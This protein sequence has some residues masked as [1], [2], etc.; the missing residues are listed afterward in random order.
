[1]HVLVGVT[2]F[3]FLCIL[4]CINSSN[5]GRNNPNNEKGIV[6]CSGESGDIF[7]ELLAMIIQIR[8]KLQSH[9]PISVAHC[10]ELTEISKLRLLNISHVNVVNLCD[11]SVRDNN[12]LK[13][14][15]CKPM[16][17]IRSPFKHTILA[18]TDVIWFAKP[19]R[20]FDAPAFISTGALYF[21]DRLT[22]TKNKLTL[23]KGL[24][25]AEFLYSY[26]NSMY[27]KLKKS[28]ELYP[29]RKLQESPIHN[30]KNNS[31]NEIKVHKKGHVAVDWDKDHIIFNKSLLA[32]SNAYWRH[33][34]HG[35]GATL[36]HMQDSSVVVFDSSRHPR[37][38]RAIRIMLKDF[39]IGYGDKEMYWISSLV[40]NEAFTFEPYFAG[41]LGNCGALIHF[42]PTNTSAQAQP[43]YVNAEYLIDLRKMTK[44]GDFLDL[45]DGKAKVTFPNLV[46]EQSS[47]I[48][49]L[50]QWKKMP[51][52][53]YP[54]GS[55]E[56]SPSS[57]VLAS[58]ALIEEI[59]DRQKILL[60]L[61][62]LQ[63]NKNSNSEFDHF[64]Q[65]QFSHVVVA[66]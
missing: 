21:R 55:C 36:D 57:C 8:T 7:I 11:Y 14:F 31:M 42:D 63:E 47:E 50:R 33:F 64:I 4:W 35:K 2:F 10:H 34:V 9:I 45:D 56:H 6:I 44:V 37:T 23:T 15:F 27:S 32:D 38:I 66:S 22:Q 54:C 40:A 43:F 17:L 28:Y 12:K 41:S 51:H 16:A 30:N 53:F 26:I 29:T 18:D 62:K 65:A 13:G 19:E 5:N 46:N 58:A 1:M 39:S 52:G 49:V 61:K 25:N 24:H 48:A 20:L 59:K 60:A 3:C